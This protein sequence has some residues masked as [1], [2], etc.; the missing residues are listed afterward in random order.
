MIRLALCAAAGL[1]AHAAA[2][3]VQTFRC[4][5]QR[6]DGWVAGTLVVDN[7]R[8][9]DASVSLGADGRYAECSV[10]G[11]GNPDATLTCTL[12]QDLCGSPHPDGC[13]APVVLAASAAAS[14][15]S[16]FLT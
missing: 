7:G 2:F 13:E 6:A 14:F 10:S 4:G 9:N 5:V 3:P 11:T 16:S 1:A 15:Q 8:S 12:A